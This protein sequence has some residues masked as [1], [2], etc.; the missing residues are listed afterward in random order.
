M[1]TRNIIYLFLLFTGL[2]SCTPEED[3]LTDFSEFKIAKVEVGADHR[4]VIAD[5]ISTLTLNPM[6]YQ[7]YTFRTEEGRD[8]TAYGKIPADRIAAGTVEYFL[9]DGTPLKE[10][11]FTTTD[12]SKSEQ[13]FYATAGGMKSD[14]FKAT[15]RAPFAE[16]QY[17]EITYPVVFHVIQD[18]TQNDLGQGIGSDII[19]HALELI[20]NAFTRK[21]SV[22]PNGA[23]AKVNFRLAEYDPSGKQL[24]EKGIN[25]YPMDTESLRKLSDEN[26]LN[27]DQIC[28]DYKKYLNIWLIGNDNQIVGTP[29]YILNTADLNQIK[30][31]T[32]TPMPEAEIEAQ[33]FTLKDIGLKFYATDFA[34]EE[35]SY[36]TEM[37]KFFGLLSTKSKNEDYCDDT[38]AYSTYRNPWDKN[39]S[40]SNSRLK[41]STD[42]LI[43]YS[44][45]I[46]DESSYK[47]TISMDQVK[48]IRT[49]T[50]N[51]PHRWAWKSNWAFTGK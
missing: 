42:G 25:R 13:G 41:I 22:S 47:N 50:D 18:K 5:G 4:Q 10:G 9:E 45:N 15:I 44:V 32:I 38:F 43:F 35:I 48:R 17:R 20:N 37:G 39:D 24:I 36:A 21:N 14:I 40:A 11:K 51:C 31:I 3:V 2:Q 46:M 23:N 26:I 49:I 27:N 1:K 6:L 34:I 19:Y 8:S 12:L 28:W 16:N 30:G 7:G 29:K 33:P